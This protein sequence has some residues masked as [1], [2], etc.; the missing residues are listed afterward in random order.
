MVFME[1]LTHNVMAASPRQGLAD[2]RNGAN[3]KAAKR[4][5]SAKEPALYSVDSIS[6]PHASSKGSGMYFEFLLRRAHSRK[7]VERRY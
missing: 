6:N 7:R 2:S 5:A 4:A 3:K 1:S